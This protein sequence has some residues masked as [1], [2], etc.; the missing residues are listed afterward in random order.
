MRDGH[1]RAVRALNAGQLPRRIGLPG[2]VILS[3]NG[4]VAASIFALP[5]AL[6]AD[7]GGFSPLM[8]PIVACAALLIII[9]FSWSAAAF[10]ESGGPA[11]YGAVFGRFVGFELGWV[12]YI[13]RAAAY[14]ANANVLT[15]YLARWAAGADE[16][17][18]RAGILI[19]VTALFATVNIAG[20]RKSIGFLGGLTVLK[21]VP[22][23]IAAVAAIAL[24]AP[25]PAPSPVPTLSGFEAGLLIVLYA[26]VGFEQ[27]VV[28]AGETKNPASVLPRAIFITLGVTT[29][30]Y[31]LVQL[32]YVSAIFGP[33]SDE[34]APLIDL[35]AWLAGPFGAAALTVTAMASLA[36]SLHGIMTTTPR[37]SH[38]L[39][40]RRDLPA[41]FGRVN[42]RFET[43]A[44]SIL[45]FAVL[46][47]ALA[48]S[49]SFVWLAV[50]STLARMIVYAVTIAALPRAAGERRL[51]AGHWL[52]GAAGILVCVWAA[53]QAD[54]KAWSTLAALSAV[55]VLLYALAARGSRSSSATDAVSAIHPP[56]SSRDPS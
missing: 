16:G 28:P 14:A 34:K 2:A 45:F 5:A 31:F 52:L 23:V 56:P 47:A 33:A 38:A 35:G 6:A 21:A 39:A 11:A 3:F 26:F 12:Y 40:A 51:T 13:A 4:A 36:G 49:G 30:L 55:G 10:P 37:V 17:V 9:P 24:T 32:A 43:P 7:F 18:A 46:A 42:A 20:V 29:L 48:I 27:A 41:W 8:F 54:L 15:A 22:L 53:S 19:A 44:N 25:W 50:V 1:R